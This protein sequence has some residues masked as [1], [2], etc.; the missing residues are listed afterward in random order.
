MYNVAKAATADATAA[1]L[2][3]VNYLVSKVPF[4]I[5]FFIYTKEACDRMSKM[6]KIICFALKRLLG[7]KTATKRS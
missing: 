3:I 1:T 6:P 4:I 2:A 5:C 7:Y